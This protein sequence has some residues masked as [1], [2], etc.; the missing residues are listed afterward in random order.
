MI[1]VAIQDD[2]AAMVRL[3]AKKRAAY[4]PHSKVF[5]K[6]APGVEG[7]QRDFLTA[8]IEDDSTICLVHQSQDVVDGFLIAKV[9]T[10]PPVYAPGGKAC[11]IDDFAVEQPELWQSV[12]VALKQEAEKRAQAAGA[13]V[14]IVVCEHHDPPKREAL[15][16]SGSVLTSEWF[17]SDLAK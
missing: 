7:K 6:I 1:R 16:T 3:A 8:Q 15:L 4:E 13:V 12:G 10:A 2:V 5:W 11:V 14:V 9:A 17:V